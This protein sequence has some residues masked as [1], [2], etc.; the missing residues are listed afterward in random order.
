M[1]GGKELWRT[2][3]VVGRCMRHGETM[4]EQDMERQSRAGS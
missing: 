3:E 1:L 2:R 4:R